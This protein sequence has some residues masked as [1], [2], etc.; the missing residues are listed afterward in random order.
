MISKILAIDDEPTNLDIVREI[1]DNKSRYHLITAESGEAA[2][3]KIKSFSPDIILLDIMMPGV[4]GYEVCKIIRKHITDSQVKIIMVSGKAQ[5]EERLEGYEAGADDYFTKPFAE[6]ELKAKVDVYIALIKAERETQQLNQALEKKVAER[7]QALRQTA[8]ELEQANRDLEQA[9]DDVIGVLSRVVE[10]KEGKNASLTQQVALLAK[11]LAEY[12]D[13][14]PAEVEAI[15]HAALLSKLGNMTLNESLA[16]LPEAERNRSHRR[17]AEQ[18]PIIAETT[19]L[20]I[21]SL[22]PVAKIIRSHREFVNGRGYPDKLKGHHIP[23]GSRILA[24]AQDYIALQHGLIV[25]ETLTALEAMK[26]LQS[27]ANRRYD[28][29]LVEDFAEVLK[30]MP[31]TIYQEELKLSAT[32]LTRGM[33]LTRDVISPNGILLLPKGTRLNPELI[34]NIKRLEKNSAKH[35]VVHVKA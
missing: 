25:K 7:T 4:D 21:K 20:P 22:V 3:K 15:H 10:L 9:Y 12:Q 30:K 14:N 27:N 17:I 11:N 34:D 16:R 8:Q 32:S 1:F 33:T 5:V 35:F 19:L 24:I 28:A 6:D 26:F 13:L 29:E 31:E 2:L 23:I 18:C